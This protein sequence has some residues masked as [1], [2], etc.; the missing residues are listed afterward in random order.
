M[1]TPFS[2]T[3]RSLQT[4]TA[5]PAVI[6]WT[7]AA[8]LLAAWS[9][10]FVLGEVTL[11]ELSPR[12]RV[13]VRQAAHALSAP[14][15]GRVLKTHL[16]LGQTVAAGELLVEMDA[17]AE[18]LRLAEARAR[19]QALGAQLAAL[20]REIDA[21]Q[22]AS[23]PGRQAAEAALQGAQARTREAS[24][25]LDHATDQERR[26]REEAAAGSVAAV[27]ALAARAEVLKLAA[28]RE[29]LAAE[30]RRLDASRASQAAE[31]RAQIDALL[32]QA[33]ALEGELAGGAQ[34]IDGLLLAIERLR[35]RAPVAGR[36]GEIAP[37][38]AGDVVGAGQKFASIIPGGELI[39]VA[40]FDPR[41]VLGR[42]QPGQPA[43]LRLDGFPWTQ[44]GSLA[45][46]VSRVAGEIRDGQVR[47]EF[48]A[49]PAP[50]GR[51]PSSLPLQHGLPG[52]VEIDIERVSPA[53]LVLRA[54]GQWMAGATAAPPALA[55]SAL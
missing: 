24:A 1:S 5:W 8:A 9:A 47:V 29:A 55:K 28:A 26:L 18:G 23:T 34:A 49:D 42:V 22:Q 7:L 43:R 21:R 14:G 10:W 54:S 35:L 16:L 25:A 30:A 53:V 11:H 33:A 45:A 12:A 41:A 3:T 15:P 19:L 20:R 31:Q 51:Q 48:T 4:H 46:T 13:E 32:R 2:R 38:R 6:A 40:D 50:P 37:L 44:Y 52:T 36:I 17:S 39:V 27:E